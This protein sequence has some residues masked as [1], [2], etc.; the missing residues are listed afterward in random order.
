M[1]K[2]LY[3]LLL[4]TLSFYAATAQILPLERALSINDQ[5]QLTPF[6][7][8][9]NSGFLGVQVDVFSEE[10][11]LVVSQNEGRSRKFKSLYLEPLFE[12]VKAHDGW[13]FNENQSF[14]LIIN[15]KNQ[16]HKTLHLLQREL[17]LYR[18]YLSFCEKQEM[19]LKGVT[20]VLTGSRPIV[21]VAQLDTRWL[22]LEGRLD[23]SE[24][25]LKPYLSPLVSISW[26]EHFRWQG[27][28]RIPQSE[29]SIMQEMVEKIRGKGLQIKFAG[30]PDTPDMWGVLWEEGI[31]FIG[32]SKLPLLKNFMIDQILPMPTFTKPLRS[33]G[34]TTK[35]SK[36]G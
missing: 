3:S 8:A 1:L 36:G 10:D 34:S 11:E 24:E 25:L 20:V 30:T 26:H 6:Y 2:A 27:I 35:L 5:E 33:R 18:P 21:E 17:M 16:P 29:L 23:D 15:I 7:E 19:R 32:S 14:L 28:G 4:Y 13:L 31:D 22:F 9:I 12:L